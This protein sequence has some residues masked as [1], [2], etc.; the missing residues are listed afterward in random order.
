MSNELPIKERCRGVFGRRELLALAFQKNGQ[1]LPLGIG[2]LTAQAE[3]KGVFDP[4]IVAAGRLSQH[5]VCQRLSHFK[6][7]GVV[8]ECEG[9]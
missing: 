4:I 8:K 9:L 6:K 1:T 2:R 5:S 7:H 3:S